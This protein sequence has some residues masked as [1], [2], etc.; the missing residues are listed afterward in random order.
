MISHLLIDGE[1]SSLQIGL[2]AKNVILKITFLRSL[3]SMR[4]LTLPSLSTT[5]VPVVVFRT[6]ISLDRFDCQDLQ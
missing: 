1:V 2:D 4:N 3:N 6:G 5:N